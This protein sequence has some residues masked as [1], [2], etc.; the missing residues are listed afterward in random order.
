MAD[1]E[2]RLVADNTP[3]SNAV[4]EFAGDLD[5]VRKKTDGFGANA[6]KNFKQGADSAKVF[7]GSLKNVADNVNIAGVNVGRFGSTIGNAANS[8]GGMIRGLGLLRVAFIATGIGAFV[9]IVSSLIAYFTRTEKGAEKLE[10]VMAGVGA[11]FDVVVGLVAPLGE[12]IVSAF[13]NPK[14]ALKDFGDFLLNNIINRFKAFGVI[15]EG[16]KNG[17]IRQINDGFIQLGTG[18]ENAS[19]KIAAIGNEIKVVGEKALAAARAAAEL[20]GRFQDLEDAERAS[21]VTLSE[22]NILI[23]QLIAK[24]KNRAFSEAERIKFLEKAGDLEKANLAIELNHANEQIKLI[25]ERNAR[26]AEANKTDKKA[27]DAAD[28]EFVEATVKRNGLIQASIALQEKVQARISALKDA[29]QQEADAAL[30]KEQERLDKEKQ[31]KE[32]QAADFVELNKKALESIQKLRENQAQEEQQQIENNFVNG[33]ISEEEFNKQKAEAHLRFLQ[34][35]LF[36]LQGFNGEAGDLSIEAAAKQLEI[37]QFVLDQKLEQKKKANEEEIKAE[38]EK[39]QA[40]Q[41]VAQASAAFIESVGV[42]AGEAIGDA[43]FDMEKF[44]K[45]F[46]ISL[47]ENVERVLFATVFKSTA[48]ALASADS[49]ATFGIAGIAKAALLTGLIKGAFAI[50]K[51][52]IGQFHDGG[53]TGSGNEWQPAGVVHKQEFVSTKK[54]TKK[55]RPI[56]EALHSDDFSRLKAIDLRPILE[57]TGIRLIPSEAEGITKSSQDFNRE[58]A[59]RTDDMV[60][61]MKATRKM[62]KKYFDHQ[63][64][65]E[66]R[67][68]LPD[69]TV[70][71]KK[72]SVTRR[73]RSK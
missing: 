13:E 8:M 49:I 39:E 12:A 35:Q 51:A 42:L 38:R 70:E 63:T 9:L 73:I 14:Q 6:N 25:G 32:K 30:Q 33:L 4:K 23:D 34:R 15:I 36:D 65:K 69:G 31:A 43:E 3:A 22:N 72:G 71:I 7:S 11:A 20:T 46:A 62:I 67:T 16:I 66:Q 10:R 47:L 5:D 48:E 55:Y 64:N 45:K 24:S 61:E 17:S 40:I 56:L 21:K 26:S 59:Q 41:Q 68:T 1:I 19:G 18:V 57:G 27:R 50:V 52:Q 53:F 29:E 28:L 58:T 60:I 44:S 2:L 37:N 54:T